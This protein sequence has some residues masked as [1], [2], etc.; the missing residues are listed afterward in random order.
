MKE[1]VGLR[2]KTYSYVIDDSSEDKK[3]EGTIKCVTKR[4][5]KFEDY[6]NYSE[7][8]QLENKIKHLEKN[9]NDADSHRKGHKNFR[10]SNRVIIK[11]S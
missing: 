6:K 7:A 1:F 3:A 9:E 11:T 2:T 8:S 5:L 10:K 4:K